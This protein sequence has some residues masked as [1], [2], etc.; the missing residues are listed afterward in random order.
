[1]VC[2]IPGSPLGPVRERENGIRTCRSEQISGTQWDR[3]GSAC[4]AG[5]AWGRQNAESEKG[6]RESEMVG[7]TKCVQ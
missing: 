1:M 5:R 7:R 6:Q 3:N 4:H 2:R